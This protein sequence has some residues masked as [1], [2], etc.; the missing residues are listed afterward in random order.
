MCGIV[1]A[2]GSII[3]DNEKQAFRDMWIMNQVRGRHGTGL[4]LGAEV[5]TALGT[6]KVG[7]SLVWHEKSSANTS[8]CTDKMD[9][10][11]DKTKTQVLIGHSRH[12]TV[13][14]IDE[15]SAHPFKVDRIIGMHN[16]TF[17]GTYPF[18]GKASTDSEAFYMQLKACKGDVAKTIST[19]T[20]ATTSDAYCFV[21]YDLDTGSVKV[22]RNRIRP[23]TFGESFGGRQLWMS[24][25]GPIMTAAMARRKITLTRTPYDIK[26]YVLYTIPQGDVAAMTE[27]DLTEDL[28]PKY[29]TYVPNRHPNRSQW[30]HSQ[31]NQQYID[32]SG[33]Q[34]Y[35]A[36]GG[37]GGTITGMLTQQR[38]HGGP[39]KVGWLVHDMVK[40]TFT[41]EQH[42]VSSKENVTSKNKVAGVGTFVKIEETFMPKLVGK[43]TE[44]KP[45]GHTDTGDAFFRGVNNEVI[46]QAE[47]LE[48][49]KDGCGHCETVFDESCVAED[50]DLVFYLKDGTGSYVC[51][52][53]MTNPVID[54]YFGHAD[55]ATLFEP[56]KRTRLN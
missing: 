46:D 8:T 15:E 5:T 9:L 38:N 30:P 20:K 35:S 54:D 33:G 11:K 4:I 56:Q 25:E 45:T 2:I 41:P 49:T 7:S 17:E 18:S 55:P 19:F 40:G 53:C 32:R 14:D 23:M 3:I 52:D 12:A 10:S 43:T 44:K 26:P 36:R 6:K 37:Y 31:R 39:T 21:W 28:T 29:T 34:T 50:S 51:G 24:S 48:I 16:G 1:G 47:F 27:T 13:G 42:L 22:I